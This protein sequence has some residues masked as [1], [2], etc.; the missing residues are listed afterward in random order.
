VLGACVWNPLD[1]NI[2][3]AYEDTYHLYPIAATNAPEQQRYVQYYGLESVPADYGLPGQV[4][5]V[6]DDNG[7]A[8]ATAYTYD[9]FGRLATVIRP[10][11]SPALPTV[12]YWYDETT[13]STR[14]VYE[15][16]S[17]VWRD[18]AY[19]TVANW[20][21]S[22]DKDYA[23]QSAPFRVSA[24]QQAGTVPLHRYVYVGGWHGCQHD[25]QYTTGGSP[26]AGWEYQGVLGYIWTSAG[27]GRVPVYQC[28]MH[29]YYTY[30]HMLVL[31]DEP[32][33]A[34]YTDGGRPLLGYVEPATAPIRV[35][36]SQREVSGQA[37]T[38][39]STVYYDGLGRQVQARAEAEGDQW[40]VASTSYDALG[41]PEK[42]YLPRFESGVAYSVP[43]G[44]YT[45]TTY[46]ALGRAVRVDNPDGT[47]ATTVYGGLLT[48]AIDANGHQKRYTNDVWG[49]LVQ[50]E[51]YTGT[52]PSA[53]LYATTGYGYDRL[54]HLVTVTD[55]NEVTTT[56]H[57][58]GLGRKDWMDDPD[59]GHWEY[60]YDLLGNLTSQT[61]ARGCTIN[62]DY[63]A[64]NRLE[65]KSYSGTC[66]TTQAVH[67]FYDEPGYGYS[68]GRLTHM[69]DSSGS[70]TW[71][72]DAR[73]RVV[74]E[75][76]TID[77]QTFT[78]QYVY[79]AADRPVATIYPDSEVV[80]YTY[81]SG[82][83]LESLSGYAPYVQ[84]IDYNPLGQITAMAYGNGVTMQYTYH[85]LNLRLENVQ[86]SNATDTLLDLST[87]Y[88][89][90]GNV[91]TITDDVLHVRQQFAYDDLDR[92][93]RGHQEAITTTEQAIGEVGFINDTLTHTPQ[94][95]ILSRS[96]VNPV[97]FATPVSRD[98]GDT[99]V[100]RI[101]DV[102]ADRF[103]LY[104][105]E[106]P[107][108]D[109]AH[110]TE[111]VSYVVLEAGSWT[112]PDGTRLE[113]GQVNTSA[114]VGAG[115]VDD[116]WAHVILGSPFGAAPVVVS[117][118]Q[119][120][121]DPHWVKTR[122]R[123]VTASGFDVALEE[124]DANTAS[125]GG[126]I[127]GWLAIE[128]GMGTW[129]GHKYEAAQ[130]ADVVSST[131]AAI[132]FA[133]SFAS[134]PRFVGGIAT[135]DGGDGAYL[136]YDRTSLT[137]SG[138][139]VMIEEDTTADEETDHTDEVVHYLA[140][141]GSGTLTG[142]AV[143][144]APGGPGTYDRTYAYDAIGN[145]TS[146]SDVGTYTYQDP[147]HV[148]AVTHI[149]GVQRY[150]YDANGN[151]TQRDRDGD[152]AYDQALTFTAENKV[153]TVTEGGEE[154]TFTYDGNG[155][156]VKKED[157]SGTTYYVGG[158]YEKMA[159][160]GVVTTTSYYYA[161]G[162]RVA[163]RTTV[164]VST[165]VTYL[166]G[167]HLSSTSLTTDAAGALVARVLYY[168]YGETRYT[169]GTLT[170]DY[171]YTGQRNEAG[172]GLMDYGARFYDP[173]LGRFVSADTI[174]P[175]PANPQDWNR[176]AYVSNNPLKYVDPS[177]HCKIGEYSEYCYNS[178]VAE[179]MAEE[180]CRAWY[181]RDDP[182]GGDGETGEGEAESATD[183]DESPPES[184]PIGVTTSEVYVDIPPT[185][186]L[187]FELG[188]QFSG[189]IKLKPANADPVVF[190]QYEDV[191][192]IVEAGDWRF[193][194]GNMGI[195]L[196]TPSVNS[197]D[198]GCDANGCAYSGVA[199]HESG[200]SLWP[201][202][203]Q[204]DGVKSKN[205]FQL[206]DGQQLTIEYKQR[207]VVG[208][209]TAE[210]LV[211]VVAPVV[212]YFLGP[213]GLEGIQK[214]GEAGATP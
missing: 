152:G 157:S 22:K 104:V 26:G 70:A 5:Q 24:T 143:T 184:P 197:L 35:G 46:D 213:V 134:A 105:H 32:C 51:E 17:A 86:A 125:H 80:A 107:D 159:A 54:G 98:G 128:P 19:N 16:Y 206:P 203:K 31:G 145:I 133:Q 89:P 56:M 53:T 177:G 7:E 37:G 27:P 64:L 138:V 47:Y 120:D 25:T 160:G 140:I 93:T 175:E 142:M 187:F 12:A 60:D 155:A 57:Y 81:N 114:T 130:T 179:G 207:L 48:T 39:D 10:G 102:Q 144:G 78:T 77:A 50:V 73:G 28:E 15:L 188:Y 132:S 181:L 97:V 147:L 214:L 204:Y 100:V 121:N 146:K 162:Q 210:T 190:I 119:T 205:V 63:D 52:Y 1:H 173:T 62:F 151:M 99:S 193:E 116:V 131:W 115:V 33:P 101:T 40:T 208:A 45:L 183:V 66:S 103:T 168:P 156:R 111:A 150:A 202:L 74:T 11:D 21:T 182:G 139:Q 83:A 94:T 180:D 88:D 49:Q 96:Y 195:Y 122:Q 141:E 4:K 212:I 161:A 58:D 87:T 126:E 171:G 117:Q 65:E 191:I 3:I 108:R 201:T 44:P 69:T 172:L 75:T 30:D 174:V 199:A 163:M 59:M 153:Q 148:H 76:K 34:E 137:A 67:Y 41:R 209:R 85:P 166:H 42:G 192:P 170:T 2:H 18:H 9:P 68:L 127:I 29:E 113:V 61:D 164:G 84:S 178:C 72:Y 154:T 20:Q 43:G 158:L 124:E 91:Q 13:A 8:T 92:L 198:L 38:L 14:V 112:L 23:Y 118:V 82:G 129:N 110:T 200:F 36:V 6:W 194:P 196:T 55:T 135:Y 167:D 90:V 123:N 176:F 136:R 79:D 169:E 106:G 71:R 109:G 95:V 185:P 149:D 189:R 186:I 165:T 211:L